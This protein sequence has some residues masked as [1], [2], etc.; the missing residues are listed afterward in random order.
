M[1]P[2]PNFPNWINNSLFFYNFHAKYFQY[3]IK[4]LYIFLYWLNVTIMVLN[5]CSLWVWYS[6]LETNYYF[7]SV[8]L[9]YKES[10]LHQFTNRRIKGNKYIDLIKRRCRR[11]RRRLKVKGRLS[12]NDIYWNEIV[13]K[14]RR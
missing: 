7:Y 9:S 10:S 12:E 6:S 13:V 11:R 5:N 3:Q 8:H 14:R 2:N 1:N 4:L